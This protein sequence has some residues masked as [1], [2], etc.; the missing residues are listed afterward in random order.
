M[1]GDVFAVFLVDEVVGVVVEVFVSLKLGLIQ[2]SSKASGVID[3]HVSPIG[4]PSVS[5]WMTY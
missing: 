5:L 3:V 1:F 2:Y 4:D